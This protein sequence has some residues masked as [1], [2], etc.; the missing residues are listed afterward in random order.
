MT[1]SRRRHF[2]AGRREVYL[3]GLRATGCHA[4]AAREAGIT[5]GGARRYRR[6]RPEFEAA[7]RSAEEEAQRRLS[8]AEPGSRAG[9]HGQS[10]SIRRGADGRLKIQAN[11]RRRWSRKAE[12]RFFAVLRETGNIA[13]SA[14]A[15]GVSREAVW[16]RRRCWPAFARRVEE[17]LEEAE[18][19]LE[20]RVAC[21]GTNWSEASHADSGAA[22]DGGTVERASEAGPFDSEL[23]LRFLKWR[24]D[25][26]R[27]RR[28][29]VA[30]L[31]PVE[32]ARERI[33][34]KVIAMKRHKEKR[35]AER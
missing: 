29:S 34:R 31:P 25:K 19:T 10:E 20:F 32:E 28:A 22:G 15:A 4:A 9:R 11:G 26:R 13:G 1:A 23:A 24:E 2:T 18:V 27:G 17:T 30:A 35:E 6:R 8:G 7:C 3:E 14:R 16:K 21:L 5:P 12:E 33:L